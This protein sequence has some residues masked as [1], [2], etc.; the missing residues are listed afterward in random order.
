MNKLAPS[1]ISL[2]QTE[3]QV[4]KFE[5]SLRASPASLLENGFR[6]LE[7]MLQQGLVLVLE[8]PNEHM[9]R[10]LL[11]LSGLEVVTDPAAKDSGLKLILHYRLPLPALLSIISAARARE[12]DDLIVDYKLRVT[13]SASF[14][15]KADTLYTAQLYLNN[16]VIREARLER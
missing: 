9:P 8:A 2:S 16:T 3:N 12:P 15:L 1:V 13:S 14:I 6:S 10:A 11:P 5:V 4:H 7:D